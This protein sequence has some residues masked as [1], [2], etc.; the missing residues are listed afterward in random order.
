[1]VLGR[2]TKHERVVNGAGF[3]QSQ[4]FRLVVGHVLLGALAGQP[5]R[6]VRAGVAVGPRLFR[7]LPRQQRVVPRGAVSGSARPRRT[8]GRA[9]TLGQFWVLISSVNR[10]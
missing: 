6:Q 5:R 4:Q 8:P 2:G 10:L 7:K 1:M 9:S 3:E